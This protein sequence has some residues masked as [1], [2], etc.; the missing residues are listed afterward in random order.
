MV[1]TFDE[2]LLAPMLAGWQKVADRYSLRVYVFCAARKIFAVTNQEQGVRR[3][4]SPV[5]GVAA[6]VGSSERGVGSIMVTSSP[7]RQRKL[8]RQLGSMAI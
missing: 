8:N 3:A 6:L 7:K 5:C 1:V 4:I 2:D